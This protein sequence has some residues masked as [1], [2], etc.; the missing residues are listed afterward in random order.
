MV[1]KER[2]NKLLQ[3]FD[4]DHSAFAPQ[5]LV[6]KIFRIIAICFIF[7]FFY[8][9][10]RVLLMISILEKDWFWNLNLTLY[11]GNL[12]ETLLVLFLLGIIVTSALRYIYPVRLSFKSNLLIFLV[13]IIFLTERFYWEDFTFY[14][15]K[16]FK[17]DY[18]WFIVLLPAIEIILR[19]VYVSRV[20][21][22][23][24]N[25][26]IFIENEPFI[27]ENENTSR[28]TV[29]KFLSE[30]IQKSH[31]KSA[32]SI[33]IVGDWGIGKTS[34]IKSL[35]KSLGNTAIFIQFSPWLSLG[36]SSLLQGF[37]DSI[38]DK[39]A[40]FDY[41]LASDLD[42]YIA[43]LINIE[44]NANT[45]VIE[46]L[47]QFLSRK[48]DFD[49]IDR[50]ISRIQKRVVI[51]IDD[52]DRLDSKEIVEVLKLIR[53]TA[54]FGNVIYVSCYDKVYLLHALEKFNK[55]NLSIIL[56]KF[57]DLEI[58]ISPI[59][60]NDLIMRIDESF[61][62]ANTS[63]IS[64][65]EATSIKA[66]LSDNFLFTQFREV[67]KFITSLSMNYQLYG[68][69]LFIKDFFL[70]EILK[71]RYPFLISLLWYKRTDFFSEE[72]SPG[73]IV[74]TKK[75]TKASDVGDESDLVVERYLDRLETNKYNKY[76][77][78]PIDLELIKQILRNLFSGERS[79]P[80][81]IQGPN[82]FE[83]YFYHEIPDSA[84]AEFDLADIVSQGNY[85]VNPYFQESFNPKKEA[86]LFKLLDADFIKIEFSSQPEKYFIFLLFL[87]EWSEGKVSSVLFMNAYRI[88]RTIDDTKSHFIRLF[89]E[90]TNSIQKLFARTYFISLLIRG[91]IY[92]RENSENKYID[93][94]GLIELNINLFN[95]YLEL[96][97]SFS[98]WTFSALY[99]QIIDIES[100][101]ILLNNQALLVFKDFIKKYSSEY[102]DLL[103][104][105]SIIPNY[106]LTFVFEP[107]T[108]QLFS[109]SEFIDFING[110][111]YPERRRRKLLEYF[112]SGSKNS[113]NILEF[114]INEIENLRSFPVEFI[115]AWSG[116]P[117][118]VKEKIRFVETV[119]KHTF[120]AHSAPESNPERNDAV[121]R[122]IFDLNLTWLKIAI[123]PIKTD[124]WNLGLS[125]LR[126]KQFPN[127]NEG[128]YFDPDKSDVHMTIGE[129]DND[130][131]ILKEQIE[132]KEN[133]IRAISSDFTRYVKYTGEKI[134]MFLSPVD[135]ASNIWEIQM[136]IN[137]QTIGSRRY[138]L[139]DHKYF[140][141]GAWCDKRD[142]ELATEITLVQPLS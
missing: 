102:L 61:F 112:E 54:N 139:S 101:T 65:K 32:Y 118:N 56:D 83:A 11:N 33:G 124:F 109:E 7:T 135:K 58:P 10:V 78:S 104:R 41:S 52:L 116:I 81:A 20:D 100:Q 91:L 21:L 60:K 99:H 26:S 5:S 85:R 113:S 64:A 77:L 110:S 86:D 92:D 68:S 12:F 15:S 39:L 127:I 126:S 108:F 28:A 13:F 105:S 69:R 63:S 123:E 130:K 42:H 132:M 137:N 71:V 29:I 43:S 119:I 53:N 94:E 34:F 87:V 75:S 17:I 84:L 89:K 18:G 88:F 115:N 73:L 117:K 47:D 133:R 14:Q 138:N 131:W 50:S 114:K 8:V 129:Q 96:S 4:I 82:A 3:E 122:E 141:I 59:P 57:F 125:F 76:F 90:N 30:E 22:D 31:F 51:F 37:A 44:K 120:K 24:K 46:L 23:Q 128:R 49:S 38:K 40:R 67:N 19:I 107:I 95:Q 97:D 36:R 80:M 103:I 79:H 45:N 98:N 6:S 66:L 2:L 1:S 134:T 106:D 72:F 35:E 9:I 48:G 16:L 55:R 74:L 70:F 93:K 140:I 136:S 27:I 121:Y 142:F 111:D 62:K 25:K